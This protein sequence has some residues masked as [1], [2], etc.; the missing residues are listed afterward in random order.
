MQHNSDDTVEGFSRNRFTSPQ[1]NDKAMMGSQINSGRESEQIRN[2]YG[3]EP[4]E[5]S[6]STLITSAM[7]SES[8]K[9]TSENVTMST[10]THA[11]QNQVTDTEHENI[12]D[13]CSPRFQAILN[14][15]VSTAITKQN[16]QG[17]APISTADT[18]NTMPTQENDA[19]DKV[20][21]AENVTMPTENLSTTKSGQADFNQFTLFPELPVELRLAIWKLAL[22]GQ[23]Y[24]EIR[25]TLKYDDEEEDE[26]DFT[27]ETWHTIGVEK[28]PVIF[29]VCH[30]ARAE[31]V[32]TYKPLKST[33]GHGT[34]LV[35]FRKDVLCLR[36]WAYYG[37]ISTFLDDMADSQH[38]LEKTLSFLLIRSRYMLCQPTLDKSSHPSLA[39]SE[40]SPARRILPI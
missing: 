33:D 2:L 9:S 30:K 36:Y 5:V 24:V 34:V 23:R 35:D 21:R 32:K 19:Q 7:L 1:S 13:K 6:S 40:R 29:F 26:I 15:V 38:E 3:R 8:G 27:I 39:S 16:T 12:D 14:V 17:V 22:P 4:L 18:T 25:S 11:I 10:N 37:S 20:F 31:V 28:A